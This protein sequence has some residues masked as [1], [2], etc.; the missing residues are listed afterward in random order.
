[1]SEFNYNIFNYNWSQMTGKP[2]NNKLPGSNWSFI[3]MQIEQREVYDKV[4]VKIFFS[5]GDI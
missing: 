1:M 5:L 4:L 3:L 2:L